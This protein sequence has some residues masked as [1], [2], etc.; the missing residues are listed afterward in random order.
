MNLNQVTRALNAAALQGEELTPYFEQVREKCYLLAL[1]IQ[2]V[3][4]ADEGQG[5]AA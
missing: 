3:D 5:A 2:G 4:L 1:H